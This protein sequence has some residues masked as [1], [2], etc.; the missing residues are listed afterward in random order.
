MA[1]NKFK[2]DLEFG[3]KFE[4]DYVK[5]YNIQNYV[6]STGKFKPYDI[7]D[8]DTKIKYEVKADRWSYSTGN[9][10][11]EYTSWNKPSGIVTTESDFYIYYVI[12]PRE[13]YNIYKIPVSVIK[14]KI[15]KKQYF[16]TLSG[17]D[18]N[19]NTQFYL[20]RMSLFE[21]YRQ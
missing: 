8:T 13:E 4:V 7:L 6:L 5:R 1:N 3:Q 9:I 18:R 19:S 16:R 14:D 10:C 20:F 12:K 21:V 11:I 15:N 17:G 2:K